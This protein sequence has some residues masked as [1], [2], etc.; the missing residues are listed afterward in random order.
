MVSSAIFLRQ[1][2]VKRFG[3][4]ALVFAMG[5][6]GC[7][8][9]SGATTGNGGYAG[10]AGNT[11]GSTD[12]AL[13]DLGANVCNAGDPGAAFIQPTD[14]GISPAPNPLGGALTDGS[15]HL[16]STLYYPAGG[17]S[18]IGVATQLTVVSSA[19]GTGTLQTATATTAGDFITESVSFT[20]KTAS[21]SVRI[22]CIYPDPIGLHGSS[23]QIAYS[24]SPTEI[25][26]YGASAA[27][28]NRID[29]Y[30]LD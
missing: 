15:Y 2:I 9:S 24:A 13:S 4:Y 23:A 27:C 12:G 7:W 18:N 25:Q 22:D 1:P 5:L 28:G 14:S 30:E 19:S 8:G 11:D 17:C 29:F 21:L 10:N 20:I 6:T 16:T 3:R 26:L